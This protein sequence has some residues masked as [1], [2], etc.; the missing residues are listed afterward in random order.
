LG[1]SVQ[2]IRNQLS[3][4]ELEG[5]TLASG[6]RR[7]SRRAILEAAGQSTGEV[8]ERERVV[9]YARV[10]SHGQASEKKTGSSDLKRQIERLTKVAKEKYPNRELVVIKDVGS[11]MNFEKAGLDRLLTGLLNGEF[12]DAKLLCEHKDRLARWAVPL[13]EKVASHAGV[14]IEYIEQGALNDEEMLVADLLAITHLFSVKIYSKRSSER[15]KKK[16]SPEF[17]ERATTLINE[18]MS[19]RDVANQ[20][21]KEGFRDGNGDIVN[22]GVIR[23]NIAAPLDKLQKLLPKQETPA[24]KYLRLNVEKAPSNYRVS[25]V[26]LYEHYQE[27]SAKNGVAPVSCKRLLANL[28]NRRLAGELCGLV[29]KTKKLHTVR[30]EVKENARTETMNSKLEAF[31]KKEGLSYNV[32]SKK[33]GTV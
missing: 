6:H 14:E 24:M 27:W 31:C 1:V 3:R 29:V 18:G 25:I 7:L 16:L 32:A 21:E 2:T 15:R 8:I 22:Y 12:K 9:I 19:V 4:G 11:G 10:S 20:L 17:I 28:P 33:L 30:R 26:K 5:F 23:K 13:I